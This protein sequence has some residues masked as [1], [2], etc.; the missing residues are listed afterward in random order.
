MNP[1]RTLDEIIK[2]RYSTRPTK[3]LNHVYS[4]SLRG[5]NT[6]NIRVNNF[7]KISDA[8][9][10]IHRNLHANEDLRRKLKDKLN[11]SSDLNNE[12]HQ[13]SPNFLSLPSTPYPTLEEKLN[14]DNIT[15]LPSY[16]ETKK[17]Q[18]TIKGLNKPKKDSNRRVMDNKFDHTSFH[19][20]TYH[21]GAIFQSSNY[22]LRPFSHINSNNN[23][24]HNLSRQ[25]SVPRHASQLHASNQ[26][27]LITG[28]KLIISNLSSS[29][30]RRDITELCEAVGRVISV[31]L[32]QSVA[33]ILFSN[34]HAAMEAY[35]TYHNRHLDGRAMVCRISSSYNLNSHASVPPRV[36]NYSSTH[37]DSHFLNFVYSPKN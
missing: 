32:H 6:L 20:E 9:E 35:K 25:N 29:V 3:R 22:T 18:I 37:P 8:R 33:E 11:N 7:R 21:S 27:S 5:L 36:P 4:P 1:D 28:T 12:K 17:I 10:R 16:H 19:R 23:T 14:T 24:L 2:S 30:T 15:G 31:I 34:K 13:F 26:R